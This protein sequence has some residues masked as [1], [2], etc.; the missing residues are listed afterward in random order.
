[1]AASVRD[2]QAKLRDLGFDPGPVDG[3]MGRRTQG[4]L[5]AYAL[6]DLG[7][8]AP[9]AMR[10]SPAGIAAIVAHEGIVPGPY[11]DGVGVWTWGIGHT[12]SA[13]APDPRS[14]PRGMPAD[15]EA[16]LDEVFRVFARDLARFEARVRAAIRVPVAQHE[17]DAAVSFDLNTGR[18]HDARWVQVLNAGDRAGASARMMSYRKP[19]MIVPRRRAEQR[20]FRDGV[21]PAKPVSVWRVDPGGAVIW[22]AVRSLSPA[23]IAARVAP[24]VLAEA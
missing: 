18:I 20:L 10:T 22:K 5:V 19:A 9:E 7:L 17:F 15:L 16:T 24:R 12:A 6:A 2:I 1:M 13:G 14:R 4:A 8:P 21:Y 11:R 3:V 23:D